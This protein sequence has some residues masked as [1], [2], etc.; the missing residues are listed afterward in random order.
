MC[1]IVGYVGQKDCTKIL[2]DS[3]SKLEY[4]GYDSAG[5]AVVQN[6]ELL[7]KKNKGR[8]S[9]LEEKMDKEAGL[10][11]LAE[12]VIQDGQLTVSRPT[13]ILTLTAM[14]ILLLY[15]TELLKI[16]KRLKI[17]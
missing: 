17:F 16:I 10:K 1:G 15:T 3:L 8:L 6:G 5:V 11:E 13:S 9:G 4:R 14:Q 7:T 2:L 12:S